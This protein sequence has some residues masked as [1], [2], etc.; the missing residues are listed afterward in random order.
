M[1]VWVMV[2]KLG[3]GIVTCSPMGFLESSGKTAYTVSHLCSISA[4]YFCRLA[5]NEELVKV[6]EA[7]IDQC[8]GRSVEECKGLNGLRTGSLQWGWL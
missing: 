4:R 7:L 5:L 1:L 8:V 3:V 2:E 6:I